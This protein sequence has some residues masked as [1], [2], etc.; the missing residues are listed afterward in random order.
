MEGMTS[1]SDMTKE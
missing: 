1:P